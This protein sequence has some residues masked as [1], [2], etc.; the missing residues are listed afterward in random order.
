MD[1]ELNI[2]NMFIG[3]SD[4]QVL[5]SSYCGFYALSFLLFNKIIVLI[6]FMYSFEIVFQIKPLLGC[7]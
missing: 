2:S 6:Y 4:N 5:L 3:N 7:I 1:T